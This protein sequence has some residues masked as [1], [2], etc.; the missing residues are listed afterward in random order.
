MSTTRN[1]GRTVTTGPQ[2][3]RNGLPVHEGPAAANGPQ[4]PAGPEKQGLHG[5]TPVGAELVPHGQQVPAY[6]TLWELLTGPDV[7]GLEVRFACGL[8]YVVGQGFLD[9]FGAAVDREAAYAVLRVAWRVG[10]VY[11]RGEGDT[12]QGRQPP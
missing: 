1:A 12:S 6:P 7:L 3:A 8:R 9:P 10:E 11:P 2:R 4:R 5:T